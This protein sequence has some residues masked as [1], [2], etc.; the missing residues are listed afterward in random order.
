MERSRLVLGLALAALSLGAAA[1]G[2]PLNDYSACV[3]VEKARC[4][5]RA[6]CDPGFDR[7]TCDAYYEEFCRTRE[8]DGEA[9]K[10]ATTAEVDAC[11][12]AILGEIDCATLQNALDNDLDETELLEECAFTHPSEDAGTDADTDTDTDTDTATEADAG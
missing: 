4:E 1:C 12:T 8:I 6:R 9:G 11:V 10:S 3:R 2:D 7:D 5:L